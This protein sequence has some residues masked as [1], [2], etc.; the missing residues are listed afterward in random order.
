MRKGGDVVHV[1]R[2][3]QRSS[4]KTYL[5]A[6]HAHHPQAVHLLTIAIGIQLHR[7]GMRKRDVLIIKLH[8][9]GHRLHGL[10]HNAI[11]AVSNPGF[12]QRAK[13]HHTKPVGG[14]ILFAEQQAGFFRPHSVRAGGTTA[15]AVQFR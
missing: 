9:A 11:G 2:H 14:M 15:H 8:L 3:R 1:R 12:G 10:P 5:A 4:F 7:V 6:A 13:Q